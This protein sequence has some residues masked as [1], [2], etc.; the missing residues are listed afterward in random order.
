M[1][2]KKKS[3]RLQVNP[4]VALSILSQ[5]YLITPIHSSSSSGL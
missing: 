4:V 1:E 5:L 3:N 2:K